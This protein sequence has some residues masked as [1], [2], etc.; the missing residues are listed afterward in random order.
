ML[1]NS[2]ANSVGENETSNSVLSET[3]GTWSGSNTIASN[4]SVGMTS[5]IS[6]IISV[7]LVVILV[8]IVTIAF[9]IG[10]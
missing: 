3:V 8:S 7:L 9:C 10:E 2:A 1:I 5:T 4:T 6:V